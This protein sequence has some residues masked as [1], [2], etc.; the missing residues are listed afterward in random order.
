MPHN[1]P[2]KLATHTCKSRTKQQEIPES[3]YRSLLDKPRQKFCPDK[4][5]SKAINLDAYQIPQLPRQTVAPGVG[6][7]AQPANRLMKE[8][9]NHARLKLF[10]LIRHHD[11]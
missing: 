7:V 1:I 6:N 5:I 2:L 9:D 3:H 4:T 8:F 10:T 11:Y